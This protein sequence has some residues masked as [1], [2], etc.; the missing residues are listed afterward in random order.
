MGEA[1]RVSP[2]VVIPG[3]AITFR[4]VRSSGPGGQNVNKVA[5]KV[6]L[7]VELSRV[8]GLSPA[9]RSRLL[10]LATPRLDAEGRLVIVSQKTRDQHRNLEDA[11]AKLRYL[12]LRSLVAP[13]RVG[14]PAPARP[15]ANGGCRKNGASANER[16]DERARRMTD[17]IPVR[18]GQG[19]E[20]RSPEVGATRRVGGKG[21]LELASAEGDTLRHLFR[22]PS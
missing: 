19:L 20:E 6:E 17:P 16:S 12:V 3:E 10:A 4:A 7:R 21:A 22:L 11:R 9:A 15:P 14:P 8:V 18:T 13:K 2:I 1:L 5:S